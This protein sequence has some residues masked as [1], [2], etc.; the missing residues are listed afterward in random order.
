MGYLG[1]ILHELMWKE[2]FWFWTDVDDES[3][4]W[5]WSWMYSTKSQATGKAAEEFPYKIIKFNN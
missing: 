2:P 4:S 1:I 3:W 5:A